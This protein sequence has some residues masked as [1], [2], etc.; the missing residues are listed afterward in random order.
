[1]AITY[2]IGPFR[3][4]A[5]AELLFHGSASVSLSRRA[6]ALL[7]A[8]V[9]CPGIPVCKEALME[10][11]WPGLAVAESNLTVQIAALRRV[12]A[13]EPGGGQWIE[14][15]ARRGYRFVGPVS[16]VAPATDTPWPPMRRLLRFPSSHRLPSCH[17]RT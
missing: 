9:E 3:F 11:A 4:D 1:M 16:V 2:L 5:E 10:A 15:L 8:L 12:F 14:T 13:D 17:S 7:R 6:G